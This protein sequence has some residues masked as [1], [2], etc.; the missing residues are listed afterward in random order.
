MRLRLVTLG[1][2]ACGLECDVDAE[3]APR[4]LLRVPHRELV[5]L[6]AGDDDAVLLGLHRLGERAQNGVVFEQVRHRSRVADVVHR[7]DL[8]VPTPVEL[9][10]Q[11]VP[12]DPSEAVDADARP[13]QSNPSSIMLRVYR[14][15]APRA[16]EAAAAPS[17]SAFVDRT[18]HRAL[19]STR[20]GIAREALPSP[21]ALLGARRAR[22]AARA[23]AQPEAARARPSRSARGWRD[24]RSRAGSR[25]Q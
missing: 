18:S 16:A 25:S 13:A 22:P 12:P 9:R 3:V 1:K 17:P 2:E 4:Q 15:P 5:D 24:R 6:P 10:A 23:C 7:D 14:R 8:E 20:T 11:E 19:G 21:G